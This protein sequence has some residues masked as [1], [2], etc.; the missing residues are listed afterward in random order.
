LQRCPRIQLDGRFTIEVE[1]QAI[2]QRLPGRRAR[3]LV[4]YLAAHPHSTLERS[5]LIELLWQP[6]GPGPGAA[7]S[8]AALLSKTRAVLA[9]AEIRGRGGLHLVLPPDTLDAARRR[10][11]ATPKP[12][13]RPCR[14]CPYRSCRST[15]LR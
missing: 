6:E 8:F 15:P 7:A 12:P 11:I 14:S 1:E 2:E 3:L 13:P 5:A 10:G 4:A 9:P